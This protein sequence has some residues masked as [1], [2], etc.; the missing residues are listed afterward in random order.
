ML[1]N[2]H[3]ILRIKVEL[4]TMITKALSDLAC[5]PFHSPAIFYITSTQYRTLGSKYLAQ[6]NFITALFRW[7]LSLSLL[8]R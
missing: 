2:L 4:F 3:Y 1:L 6:S 8:Y 5:L 7:V